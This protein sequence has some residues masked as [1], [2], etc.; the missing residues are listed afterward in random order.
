VG[1]LLS[2][3]LINGVAIWALALRDSSLLHQGA[4]A[5]AHVVA[6]ASEVRQPSSSAAP[7]A[8]SQAAA[9]RLVDETRRGIARY[10]DPAV[11]IADSYRPSTPLNQPTVH[12]GKQGKNAAVGLDPAHPAALVYATTRHGPLL[13]GAMYEMPK[14]N[15]RPTRQARGSRARPGRRM[16]G[17]AGQHL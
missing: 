8:A 9:T 15:L 11:A 1:T 3:T 4:H 13:L 2:L 14:A 12:Y 5:G 6:F 16:R 10:Q 7:S 17:P